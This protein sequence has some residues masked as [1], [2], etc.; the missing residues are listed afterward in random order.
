MEKQKT[1][2]SEDTS[3]EEEDRRLWWC[4]SKPHLPCVIWHHNIITRN[5][6]LIFFKEQALNITG[7]KKWTQYF[8]P[9]THLLSNKWK[10][11]F[12]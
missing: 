6:Y 12:T 4:T 9:W 1:N 2:N 10:K 8:Q 5:Q 7:G 11:I 3:E